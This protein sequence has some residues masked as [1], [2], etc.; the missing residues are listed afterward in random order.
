M[1]RI[2]DVVEAGRWA[3]MSNKRS[4]VAFNRGLKPKNIFEEI[5]FKLQLSQVEFAELI[6][7]SKQRISL[8][9]TGDQFP[10]IETAIKIQAIA[11]NHGIEVTLDELYSDLKEA[12][13]END[14]AE[15]K[16]KNTLFKGR[17]N[18]LS[19]R[20]REIDNEKRNGEGG[21]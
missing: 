12:L 4:R 20:L 9:E 13:N 6:S 11:K 15:A 2:V 19:E 8:Y 21:N 1:N 5:R 16:G 10:R 14:S 7:S 18:Y 17:E 3:P